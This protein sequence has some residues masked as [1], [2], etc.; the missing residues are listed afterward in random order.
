[1]TSVPNMKATQINS[2][3]DASTVKQNFAAERCTGAPGSCP[4]G[5]AISAAANASPYFPNG[6]IRC[7]SCANRTKVGVATFLRLE[8][9][10]RPGDMK[11]KYVK[12]GNY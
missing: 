3:V 6:T 12:Y 10:T 8:T 1:M 11:G 4:G 7:G 5:N 2:R 9:L